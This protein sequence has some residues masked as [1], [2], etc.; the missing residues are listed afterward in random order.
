MGI[1]EVIHCLLPCSCC[2]VSLAACNALLFQ[3]YIASGI[4]SL[5]VYGEGWLMSF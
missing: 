3:L 5:H 2:A 4:L 1:N